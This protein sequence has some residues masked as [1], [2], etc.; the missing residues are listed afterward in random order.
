MR[1]AIFLNMKD[2]FSIYSIVDTNMF[3]PTFSELEN[4][5]MSS[6]LDYD[7]IVLYLANIDME[8]LRTLRKNLAFHN[9]KII[10]FSDQIDLETKRIALREGADFV[11]LLPDNDEELK[12]YLRNAHD[13][14]IHSV[15]K[16]D[17]VL[18]PFELSMVETL[19][20]MAMLD[21]ELEEVYY[22]TTPFHFGDMS[23]IMALA[24]EKKGVIL[25]SFFEDLAKEVIGAIMAID[26][27]EL[28]E[29]DV[30]DGVAELL[31]MLAGGAK[32]RLGDTEAH[33][34]LSA[35]SVIIGT[36]HR[37]IQQK[38]MPCVVMVYRIEHSYFAI[39]LCLMALQG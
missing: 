5:S 25:I 39:Q 19:R 2:K 27:A 15:C 32:A 9:R 34:L 37:V 29:D 18:N 1:K 17:D 3:E 4:F 31:N 28:T 16:K 8:I 11:E 36:Q 38:D 24:G 20:T 30:H 12:E 22:T 10:V 23:G 33:F 21:A 35:P 13:C 14:F 26:P 6:A 7:L